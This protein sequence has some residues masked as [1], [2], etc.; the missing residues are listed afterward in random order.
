MGN[1]VE[2]GRQLGGEV[3]SDYFSRLAHHT[4]VYHW[5]KSA[6]DTAGWRPCIFFFFFVPCPFQGAGSRTSPCSLSS[7]GLLPS[8]GSC[9]QQ[10]KITEHK[11]APAVSP[12]K[13][14]CRRWLESRT[15]PCPHHSTS[16]PIQAQHLGRGLCPLPSQGFL[17]CSE[18]PAD[19]CSP[20]HPGSDKDLA[21][22][23]M[24]QSTWRNKKTG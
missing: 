1:Q 7:V 16:A 3:D 9:P 23:A 10:D 17:L 15:F 4:R 5:L 24:H 19:S 2:A 18:P 20:G 11:A 22:Q 13:P 6:G 21:E 12:D 14:T 8:V